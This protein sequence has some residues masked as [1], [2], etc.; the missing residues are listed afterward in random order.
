M[1]EKYDYISAVRN[2][3]SEYLTDNDI[4]LT[5][6]NFDD[7][8]DELSISDSVTGNGSGSY[9]FSSW[10]AEEAICHNFE[11]LEEVASEFGYEPIITPEYIN[12]PEAWDV[13]IR[14]YLLYQILPE[15]ITE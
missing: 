12:S 2:D 9:F 8:A 15:F 13:R 14:C 4:T 3:I 7:I 10:K 1:T 6:D 11:L 5:D